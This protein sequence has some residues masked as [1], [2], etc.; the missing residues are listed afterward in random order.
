VTTNLTAASGASSIEHA[1]GASTHCSLGIEEEFQLVHPETFDLVQRSEQ[2][3]SAATEEDLRCIK[4]ELMQSVIETA[5]GVCRGTADGAREVLG[6][7]RRVA[8][9][10]DGAGCAIASAGT[11]PFARYEF[12]KISDHDRYREI[13][14]S[15]RWVA[16]RELIFGLHVHVGL[17]STEQ[18]IYV[19]NAIRQY[20][21]E[22]LALSANSPFWQGKETGLQS[23]RSKVFDSFPRSGI[24]QAF[25][26]WADYEALVMRMMRVGAIKDYSYIWWDVRPHP[27]FGTIEVRVCDAQTR[28]ADSLALA[29]LIQATCAWLAERFDAGEP[30]NAQP[31]LLINE[32]KWSA[33]RHG[34]DGEF[35]DLERDV[36]VPTRQAVTNLIE[37]VEPYAAQLGAEAQFAALDGLLVRNGAVRQLDEYART[38]SLM[39]VG[40]LL[41]HETSSL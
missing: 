3:I 6:L 29:A 40:E 2:L 25:A 9:L 33:A 23:S 11:H 26:G 27:R 38:G 31:R 15:L 18:A 37:R 19:F 10:A 1:Y 32:N 35:I 17:A 34:L 20:L 5:T 12:Q 22:L 7:R 13:I 36:T 28:A 39:S 14:S 16:E 4:R 24:P 21:P 8:E 30:L 41:A